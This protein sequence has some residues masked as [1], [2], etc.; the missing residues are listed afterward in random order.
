MTGIVVD[1]TPSFINALLI[2]AAL[3]VVAAFIYL[4]VAREPNG[5]HDVAAPNDQP[6]P[7]GA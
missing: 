6:S 1:Q 4:L 5:E 3:A 7:S 2:S